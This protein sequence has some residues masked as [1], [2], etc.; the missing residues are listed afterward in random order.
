MKS[1]KG[2]EREVERGEEYSQMQLCSDGGDVMIPGN[3]QQI[4]TKEEISVAYF[5]I[6]VSNLST[7][8]EDSVFV[9]DHLSF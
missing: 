7:K 2:V 4:K 9:Q 8:G 1:G 6:L 5:S 3:L